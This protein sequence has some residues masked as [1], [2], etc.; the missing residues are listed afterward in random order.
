MEFAAHSS[1]LADSKEGGKMEEF[2]VENQTTSSA[3]K[4]ELKIDSLLDIAVEI[5]VEI[6]RT[7][8]SIG[9]LFPCQK[10]QLLN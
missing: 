5:S 8:M 9:E 2:V 6:G 7:K 3:K 4:L 10:D 1:L